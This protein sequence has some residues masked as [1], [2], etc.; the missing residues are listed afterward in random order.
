MSKNIVVFADGT[1]QEGGR[2]HNTN[3]YDLFNMIED[4]TERQVSY[5]D[6]GLGTGWRMVSGN[7]AGAGISKNIKEC[8]QFISDNY[9]AGDRIFLFGFSRGATTVR[10]LS[11]FIEL[12]GMLPQC[13]PELIDRAYSIYKVR[14]KSERQKKADAFVAANHTMWCQI[15]FIGVW[16]TVAALGVPIKIV[17]LVLDWLPSFRHSFHDLTLAHCVQY[18]R[19]A[20]AIDDE[21]EIFHPTLWEETDDD[22]S[23]AT[24]AKR[25]SAHD[26]TDIYLVAEKLRVSDQ[27]K[28]P[29]KRA[30]KKK[31]VKQALA[32][33]PMDPLLRYFERLI[34]ADGN[35]AT[36]RSTIVTYGREEMRA[37]YSRLRELISRFD[38]DSTR[39]ES[40]DNIRA[41]KTALVDFFNEFVEGVCPSLY[42]ALEDQV[43]SEGGY[44]FKDDEKFAG[45]NLSQDTQDFIKSTRPDKN[46]LN[47]REIRQLN[48]ILL[49]DAYQLRRT[50][51]PRI[52]QVWFAGMH[53]D[54]GGGY[55][56]R[57]LSHVP[58]IWMLNEAMELGLLVYGKH[59]TE[60]RPSPLGA[61]HDSREGILARLF[62]RQAERF[63][64]AN[65][66]QG[67]NPIVHESVKMRHTSEGANYKP[68]ILKMQH[69]DEPWPQSLRSSIQFDE[70]YIW[71]EQFWGWGSAFTISWDKVR[72]LRYDDVDRTL[73]I[74]LWERPDV[75]TD[76]EQKS[77]VARGILPHEVNN[78][79]NEFE[80][81][82]AD[83]RDNMQDQKMIGELEK[84]V[85]DLEAQLASISRFRRVG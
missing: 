43:E 52:K 11:G 30:K 56:E 14:N 51:M 41:L 10:T 58:L 75:T 85:G 15:E 53:S 32:A 60:L 29:A 83:Q 8:Y 36:G 63:W 33:N 25:F 26:I 19:Q 17:N 37:K 82:K 44:N 62:Y 57:G 50:T 76:D 61:M 38:P 80:Q 84:K 72:H 54:I 64:D 13:R 20:L 67:R 49:E 66:N 34:V 6:K 18:A 35:G 1:G 28:K 4:R 12:F 46:K 69:D 16:D 24:H 71:R 9:N 55:R 45:I 22:R 7:V 5:Y 27:V 77:I 73:T 59:R 40:S 21:R 42:K 3:V 47:R 70:H 31:S 48:R 39:N 81:R 65:R 79:L 68:W 78:L 23:T 2:G 74:D